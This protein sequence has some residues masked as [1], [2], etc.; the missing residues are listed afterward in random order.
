[1]CYCHVVESLISDGT[2]SE[3]QHD[4]M[5]VLSLFRQCNLITVQ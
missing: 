1:M 2:E 4:A 3:K 5:V